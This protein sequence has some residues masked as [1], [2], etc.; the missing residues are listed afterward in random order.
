MLQVNVL[1]KGITSIEFLTFY[2]TL[3]PNLMSHLGH[4]PPIPTLNIPDTLTTTIPAAPTPPNSSFFYG[5][6]NKSRNVI[7]K[8]KLSQNL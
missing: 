7:G 2:I 1:P 3:K 5:K 8:Q 6:G 4:T